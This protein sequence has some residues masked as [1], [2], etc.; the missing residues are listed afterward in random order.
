[1]LSEWAALEV[2]AIDAEERSAET[3]EQEAEALVAKLRRRQSK[4]AAELAN[5]DRQTAAQT[6]KDQLS[7]N[8]MRVAIELGKLSTLRHRGTNDA[9]SIGRANSALRA[10]LSKIVIRPK[11]DKLD[12]HWLHGGVAVLEML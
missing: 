6:A 9:E 3:H 11:Q 7:A 5:I 1:M 8:L 2:Q 10:V 12:L 4:L